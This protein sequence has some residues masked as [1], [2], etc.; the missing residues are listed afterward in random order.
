MKRE[1]EVLCLCSKSCRNTERLKSF[2]GTG[3]RSRSIYLREVRE[4]EGRYYSLGWTTGLEYWTHPRMRITYAAPL[5]RAVAQP[6]PGTSYTATEAR[7]HVEQLYLGP[8]PFTVTDLQTPRFARQLGKAD[9]R[10]FGGA[11][12]FH[13]SSVVYRIFSN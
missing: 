6:L 4:C 10:R 2:G 11:T 7:W 9:N 13:R 1:Q 5:L 3:I 8:Y 12:R